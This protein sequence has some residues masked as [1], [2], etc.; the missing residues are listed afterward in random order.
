M[1]NPA[2][3]SILPAD[4]VGISAAVAI[5]RQGGLV[6][7]PTETVYGL[8]AD[9]TNDN[10]VASIFA[11]KE[12]PRFNPL[13][14]HVADVNDAAELVAFDDGARA[15]AQAYWPG[16][17]TLVLPRRK[18]AGISLLT[19]AGL[20]TIAVRVPSHP[21]AQALLRSCDLPI[22][23]PSANPSG[24]ASPTSAM[25]V[26]GDLGDRVE[27]ILDGG[28]VPIGIESTIVGFEDDRPVMLR[29]GA[30][31]R[32]LIEAV[33]GSVARA[34]ADSIAAPGQLKRHYAPKTPLRLEAHDVAP[35]EALLAFGVPEL[36]GARVARNL[37][38]QG[39]LQEAAAHLFAMMRELDA[40]GS[41]AIAVMPIPNEGLGEAINDRL[42][43][44][45][46]RDD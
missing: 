35:E 8:G 24:Q 25:H 20:D 7:F 5:I 14:V 15:L 31:S 13:I 43:R 6:A 30:L 10:A 27:L 33:I 1:L 44:A 28:P 36:P 34:T 46:A 38:P 9:A 39:N 18:T 23:A 29:V 2:H 26:A 17:L 21:V 40:T 4:A 32:S 37:S 22:A 11:V 12:R 41:A 19:S 16:P 3:A 42:R 45:A